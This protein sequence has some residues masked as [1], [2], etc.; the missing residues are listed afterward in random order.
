M[1][2]FVAATPISGPARI[3]SVRSARRV[4]VEPCTLVTARV[5]QLWTF[6]FRRAARVSA[7]SPDCVTPTT[8]SLTGGVKYLNSDASSTLTGI[9]ETLEEVLHDHPRMV[10]RAAGDD[11]HLR[12]PFT[13]STT[14]GSAAVRR[15]S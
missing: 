13:M 11:R 5:G 14:A 3:S 2:D 7:V 15:V 12:S 1:K 8:R 4:T 10:G 6:A 9:G